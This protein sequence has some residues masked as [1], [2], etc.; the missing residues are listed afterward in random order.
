MNLPPGTEGVR[1]RKPDTGQPA[2]PKKLRHTGLLQDQLRRT[3]R[4][5]WCPSLSVAFRIFMAIRVTGAMYSIIQD[6]DEVYNFWEPLHYL[7]NN[8]GFQTWELS[9][10]HAIRSWAYLLLHFPSAGM[11]AKYFTSDKR[12]GFFA[13]RLTLAAVSSF[14][15]A[16]FYRAV[17]ESMNDRLGRYM[18]FMLVCSAGMWNAATAFISSS[19]TMYTTML[20]FSYAFKPP[21][22]STTYRTRATVLFFALGGILG[23]PFSLLIAVPFV[24]EEMFVYG[25]D[26][27]EPQQWSG[28]IVARWKRLLMSGL[29]ASTIF[30]PV[31][32]IDTLA[33]GKLVIVPWNIVKYNIFGGTERGPDLYGT[34]PWYYYIHN[35]ILNF[36]LVLPLALAS[37][38]TLALTH[39]FDYKRLGI[40]R[41]GPNESSP[42]TLLTIRLAPLYLWLGMLSLQPHKEERFMYPVYPLLCFNAATTL[43]LVR[44]LMETAFVKATASPYRA[45]RTSIFRLTTLS[46]VLLSMIISASRILALSRYY[47]APLDVA[48]HFSHQELPRLLNVTGLLPPQPERKNRNKNDPPDDPTYDLTPVKAFNL[49]LCYG[50][51][52][53]RFQGHYLVPDHITVDFIEAGYDKG[54]PRHFDPSV[55]GTST[56]WKREKT[57]MVPTDLNDRNREEPSHY[58]DVNTCDYLVELDEP[59]HEASSVYGQRYAIDTEAWDRV[60][61]FPFLDIQY[62]SPVTRA[63]WVPGNAWQQHNSF[64][65]YCLLRNRKLALVRESTKWTSS[66]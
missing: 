31:I 16:K 4:A 54:L 55:G 50:K 59:L 45:G 32:G 28:W 24:L 66:E 43:Y 25:L 41:H 17:V 57:R 39:K 1:L 30:I 10:T 26:K 27:V 48:H 9:P 13:V 42:F 37:L 46:V 3:A 5:P 6:C 44:G 35:L 20:A 63:L 65:D 7:D 49:R 21:A 15:E 23:W 40:L 64:S 38:P 47:H 52:W 19:F 22:Q 56:F 18:L 51:E 11:I 53:H 36:N 61:C 33:Y 2:A 60:V 62:S 29:V 34:S 14:C 58:V 8:Y 12:Q